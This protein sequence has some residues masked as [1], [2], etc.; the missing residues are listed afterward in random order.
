MAKEPTPP[1]N[2]PARPND[3]EIVTHG[4]SPKPP[5]AVKPPPPPAPPP[6]RND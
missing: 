2:R 6:K 1:P 3:G 4:I 5:S